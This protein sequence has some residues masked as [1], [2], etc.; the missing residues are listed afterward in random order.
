MAKLRKIEIFSAGCALCDD[1]LKLGN[2]IA[3]PA[4]GKTR[5]PL[6]A[7][8]SDRRQARALRRA[9]RTGRSDAAR[10]V[11]LTTAPP[12]RLLATACRPRGATR[13]VAREF[14]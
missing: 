2:S 4:R 1:T 8:G 13:C 9:R 14:Y 3:G 6:G 11:D 5:C 10:R 7:C 12:D